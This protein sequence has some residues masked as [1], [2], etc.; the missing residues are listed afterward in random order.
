[1]VNS[2]TRLRG[3]GPQGEEYAAK[4]TA[5]LMTAGKWEGIFRS[6]L[7]QESNS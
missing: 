6:K 7:E 2:V 3:D 5:S 1:M 4:E